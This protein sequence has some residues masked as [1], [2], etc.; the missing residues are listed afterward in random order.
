MI[1]GDC[2][3]IMRGIQSVSVDLIVTSPP[4]AMM[5][6]HTYGGTPTGDYWNWF[7]PRASEMQR[8]LR[9]DGSLVLNIKENVEGVER[10]TYV[11]ELIQKMRSE[12]GWLW[13]EEYIWHKPN[14]MP[15]RFTKRM[16]DGFERCLHFTRS[17]N[18]K[19]YKKE[20]MEPCKKTTI[21]LHA[22]DRTMDL[23]PEIKRA[24]DTRKEMKTGSGHG[25]KYSNFAGI[26]M[27][28]PSNVL[29][30]PVIGYNRGHSAVF[31]PRLPSFFIRLFTKEG[32]TVLDP[33]AGSGT[34]IEVAE[35]L[36]RESIGIEIKG[37][38]C[39]VSVQETK[40]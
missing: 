28:Y 19:I 20:V 9:Y 34:T 23:F 2:L 15:G 14:P 4:Y 37:E 6:S 12:L 21:R 22:V 7:K 5:R 8:V 33:F 32:D 26:T 13:V 30:I 11:L 36:G 35:E 18:F 17:A 16:K 29:T 27:A 3:D 25:V 24:D 10:S 31:P 1:Y 38:S 39:E 40:E